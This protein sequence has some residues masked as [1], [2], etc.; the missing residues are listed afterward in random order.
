MIFRATR[1]LIYS[2]AFSGFIAPVFA[3]LADAEQ[4]EQAPQLK[5][6]TVS[7][8]AS[9][10]ERQTP[11]QSLSI[12]VIGEDTLRSLGHTHISEALSRVPGVWL[13]RG[14]GQEHLTA[15]RSAVLTGAGGCGAFYFAE[16]GIPLRSNG[17]CNVNSL[18][19]ANSEQ[20]QRIEVLRGPGTAVH[21]SNALNGVINVISPAVPG[22][23]EHT[24][25]I[26]LE[27]GPYD[28]GRIK[29]QYG[30][31]NDDGGMML[32][33][34]GES[35][36]GYKDDSGYDQQKMT[37]RHLHRGE[38]WSITS[39]LAA[40]NL[41]QETAGYVYGKD[42]YKDDDLQDS[43]PNPEAFRNSLSVRYHSR[44]EREGSQDS[45]I[46]I[47][48]YLRFTEMAFL[49]HFF[50]GTPLEENG[51]RSAGLQTTFF[52]TP[53]E[54]LTIHNGFDAEFT[55]AYLQ[56]GQQAAGFGPFPSG[57]HYDY[58][59]DAA[60]AA[61]FIGSDWQISPR[62]Q[63]SLGLRYDI[64]LYQYDNKLIDGNTAADGS[65]CASSPCR[66][67]RPGDDSDR[68]T[69]VSY[70]LGYLANI[71][72]YSDLFINA[73]HGFRAPQAS[74][75]YRL[76]ANQLD[77]DELKEESLDSLE[78]GL[79]T[80]WSRLIWQASVYL[81]DKDELI[82]KNSARQ[83]FNGGATRSL[84]LELNVDWAITESF[85][86]A[87]QAAYARHRYENDVLGSVNNDLDTAPRTTASTQFNWQFTDRNRFSLEAVHMGK[88]FLEAANDH[89]Y[90][91]HTLVNLRWQRDWRHNAYSIV[92][93]NNVGDID[94][95]ERA[96]YSFGNYRYF[97]GEPRAVF[98]ELGL[99]Y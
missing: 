22:I 95:A 84:G 79:R 24:A 43:N 94:Y 59:V 67:A 76:Q 97:V 33:F 39:Q 58:E 63:L 62:H 35:D 96:D 70:R 29:L 61:W 47:S 21:G 28:Y 1:P 88:Y 40:S 83:N 87:L 41:N 99:R 32:S 68:F 86:W 65:A 81:I 9:R 74:E 14:N 98:I 80:H 89:D 11:N 13:S 52:H 55:Q 53:S 23:G 25:H 92:R 66:Y 17:F 49:Q 82:L 36:N 93:V 15:I 18:F 48:P 73:A 85:S 19:D 56:Q 3:D 20:A 60:Y 7:V 57:A 45:R 71:T 5:L 54:T 12:S 90:Q 69:N 44:F 78:L 34:H 42:A 16:D 64:Q 91:G 10:I 75:L 30:E 4:S 2:L 51:E 26:A 27:A 72:D 31:G 50:P 77:T 38:V 6:E 8:I 46:V 37:L